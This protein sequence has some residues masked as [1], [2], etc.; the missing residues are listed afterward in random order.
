[1]WATISLMLFIA[2]TVGSILAGVGAARSAGQRSHAQLRSSALQI[3]ATLQL[4][5][6][7]E[8]DLIV[9]AAGFVVAEPGADQ[10]EFVR[11]AHSVQVL[12]RYP[13][14]EGLGSIARCAVEVTID[15][16][17]GQDQGEIVEIAEFEAPQ[18]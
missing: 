4:A 14:L 16:L 3:A 13:E 5:I 9:S 15:V 7:G 8:A 18:R 6:R 1:M 2:G 17:V 10:R 11:W 12:Q